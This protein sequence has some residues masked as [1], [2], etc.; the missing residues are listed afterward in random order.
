MAVIDGIRLCE[1]FPC[2]RVIIEVD[3]IQ[4][5]ECISHGRGAWRLIFLIDRIVNLLSRRD[6]S[7]QYISREGN[8]AA[9]SLA[10]HGSQSQTSSILDPPQLPAQIRQCI[11]SDNS[12][13][14][15]LRF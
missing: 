13:V 7:I 11:L 12:N 2:S 4:T 5:I 1:T 6:W 15:Y 14:P 3:S 9:D 8:S 10:V